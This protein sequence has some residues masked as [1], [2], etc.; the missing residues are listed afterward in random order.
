MTNLT[1]SSMYSGE[2]SSINGTIKVGETTHTIEATGSAS[3]RG[4]HATIDGETYWWYGSDANKDNPKI[5][6]AV[7]EW[8]LKCLQNCGVYGVDPDNNWTAK[9]ENGEIVSITETPDEDD[10]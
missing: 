9:I 3:D 5:E 7:E 10:E 1:I 6:E 8:Y 2:N 4:T